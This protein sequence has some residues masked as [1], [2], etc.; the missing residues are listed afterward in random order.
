MTIQFRKAQKSQSKIRLALIA[1]SGYG[2][3]YSALRI[4]KGI[5][6]KIAVIDTENGSGDLYSDVFEYDIVT[7]KPPYTAEKYIEMIKA[8]EQFGYN[9]IIIDS[10]SHAWAGEGGLLDQQGK[11][12]DSGRNGFTAWRSITPKHNK[13]VETILSSKCH[14]ISTMRAKTEYVVDKNDNGKS[15]IKKIGLSPVQRDGV[16]YEFTIVFDIDKNHNVMASKDRTSLFDGKIVE[17][18]EKI[19]EQISKWL[20]AENMKP[21]ITHTMENVQEIETN[22]IYQQSI[23]IAKS[24]TVNTI[25]ELIKKKGVTKKYIYEKYGIIDR[26]H[27]E[28]S[29]KDDKTVLSETEA[30]KI[31]KELFQLPDNV[32]KPF[33]E[34][35]EINNNKVTEKD[36]IQAF[37]GS[38]V[39]GTIPVENIPAAFPETI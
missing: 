6:G 11:I 5:G 23:V 29:K 32:S 18:S 1:P 17:A 8:A 15:E 19:G 38:A 28:K 12:A 2:K 35:K 26:E 24:G 7:M 34:N 30:T 39:V 37:P 16:E 3:T 22:P 21:I 14:I 4:A 13:L 9:T 25:I 27:L 10:L 31:V 20:S 33:S 36:I